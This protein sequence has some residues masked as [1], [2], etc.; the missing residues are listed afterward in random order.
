MASPARLQE[1]RRSLSL[2]SFQ[3]QERCLDSEGLEG[4]SVA[5]RFRSWEV[6]RQVPGPLV[7]LELVVRF[8]ALRLSVA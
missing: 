1:E 2:P 7:G 4:C 6:R 3:K 8:V 5:F